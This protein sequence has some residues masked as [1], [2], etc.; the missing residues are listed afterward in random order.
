MGG[1]WRTGFPAPL[2]AY[3]YAQY[4]NDLEELGD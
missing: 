3:S 4:R 2:P 1:Y